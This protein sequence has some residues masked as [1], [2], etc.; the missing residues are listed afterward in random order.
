MENGLLY[1]QNGL[2]E[3]AINVL[4]IGDDTLAERCIALVESDWL[5]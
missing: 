2:D 3:N 1:Y 5:R 4:K